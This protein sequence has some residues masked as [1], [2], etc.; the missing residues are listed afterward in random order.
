MTDLPRPTVSVEALRDDI[1]TRRR[2]LSTSPGDGQPWPHTEVD[3][4]AELYYYDMALAVAANVLG[5]P[6]PN[7]V[8]G[9]R[10]RLSALQRNQ[11]EERLAAAG[12]DVRGADGADEPGPQGP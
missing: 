7:P 11:L 4:S 3:T 12:C 2:K 6:A 10:R 5:V 8:A 9:G 1:R